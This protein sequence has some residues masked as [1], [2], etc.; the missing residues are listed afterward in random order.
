MRALPPSLNDPFTTIRCVDQL[1][2]ALCRLAQR[3]MPSP[4]RYDEDHRLRV[5]A[6]GV[7]FPIIVDAAFDKIRRHAGSSIAVSVRLL[8]TI[9]VIAASIQQ[10]EDRAALREQAKMI[11]R[12][13]REEFLEGN[14]RTVVEKQYHE[15]RE[16]LRA[17]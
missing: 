4:C 11:V 7:T 3:E 2:S 1:G 12:R 17:P 10:P 5:I 16:A 14:D 8:E 13:A 15:A 9:P 6:P